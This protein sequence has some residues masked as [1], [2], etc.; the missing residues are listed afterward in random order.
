MSWITSHHMLLTCCIR[1]KGAK[2]LLHLQ[3]FFDVKTTRCFLLCGKK[4][5][6]HKPASQANSFRVQ[7]NNTTRKVL[8]NQVSIKQQMRKH[9]RGIIDMIP[10]RTQ[11]KLFSL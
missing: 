10:L 2:L 9:S 11:Q 7:N 1:S 8:P 4:L 6:L 5:K 3:T